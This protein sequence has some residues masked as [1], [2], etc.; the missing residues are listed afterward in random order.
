MEQDITDRPRRPNWQNPRR[1]RCVLKDSL[2]GNV[3]QEDKLTK[4]KEALIL[5][6]LI[7]FLP[8]RH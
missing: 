5:V 8:L 6:G 4:I 3:S 2:S 1:S 7:L